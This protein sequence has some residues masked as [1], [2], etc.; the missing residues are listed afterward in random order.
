MDPTDAPNYKYGD[1]VV[2]IP[3]TG[4]LTNN[5]FTCDL[6]NAW[7]QQKILDLQEEA[8]DILWN[9]FKKELQIGNM[10]L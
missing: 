8:I 4:Q 6:F 5:H 3:G 1:H 10:E 7:K 2:S 9:P